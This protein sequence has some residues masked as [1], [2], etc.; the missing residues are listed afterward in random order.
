MDLGSSPK[1]GE[2]ATLTV[3]IRKL[4]KY[5]QIYLILIKSDQESNPGV[6]NRG[7]ISPMGEI[8]GIRG[9]GGMRAFENC[10]VVFSKLVTQNGSPSLLLANKF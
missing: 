2:G 5:I 10:F 1:M 7:E 6:L 4:P 3:V 8:L 9:G